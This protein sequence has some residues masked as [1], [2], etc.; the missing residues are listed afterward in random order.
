MERISVAH[1]FTWDQAQIQDMIDL[2]DTDMDGQLSL[3]DFRDM[4]GRLKVLKEA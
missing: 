4:G 2:F 3:E 1:D